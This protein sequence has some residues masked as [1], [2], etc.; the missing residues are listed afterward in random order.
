MHEKIIPKNKENRELKKTPG[1]LSVSK[2][3]A[4]TYAGAS[5]SLSLQ[6]GLALAGQGQCRTSLLVALGNQPRL[7]QTEDRK[8][9]QSDSGQRK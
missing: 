9:E 5:E 7:S 2:G 1:F 3:N 4:P 8:G 6:T